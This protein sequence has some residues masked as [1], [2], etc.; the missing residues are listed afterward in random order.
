MIFPAKKL[1]YTRGAVL[2]AMPIT[3]RC[4]RHITAPDEAESVLC[5]ALTHA[6]PAIIEAIVDPTEPPLPGHVTT[7]QAWNFARALARGQED[8]WDI[9]KTVATNTVREVI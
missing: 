8:R 7:K 1:S 9:L 4:K 2:V 3:V 6:G 5:A